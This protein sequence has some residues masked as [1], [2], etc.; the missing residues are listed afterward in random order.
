VP[1]AAV[2]P[3][4]R[5]VAERNAEDALIAL[6][7]LDAPVFICAALPAAAAVAL[8]AAGLAA[9]EVDDPDA[10]V[11]GLRMPRSRGAINM[12]NRSAEVVPVRR[13]VL[14]RVPLVTRVVRT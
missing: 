11:E 3:A 6:P 7:A 5:L 1:G 9:V 14:I 12:A 8:A 13:I 4:T 2:A 10:F